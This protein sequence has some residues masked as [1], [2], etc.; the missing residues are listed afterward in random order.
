MTESIVSPSPVP[1]NT[2]TAEHPAIPP[3][4]PRD[5][6]RISLVRAEVREDDTIRVVVAL[7]HRSSGNFREAIV[8][9]NALASLS[10]FRRAALQASGA[11][12]SHEA[13]IYTPRDATRWWVS[14]VRSALLEGGVA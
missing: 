5:S 1:I 2:P 4:G 13:E 14:E 3:L 12:I 11:M 10:A 8:R 9:R 6:G 7:G